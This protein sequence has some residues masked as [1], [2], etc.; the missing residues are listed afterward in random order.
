MKK[1]KLFTVLLLLSTQ[2]KAQQDTSTFYFEFDKVIFT[3]E[4]EKTFDLFLSKLPK[5]TELSIEVSSDSIG[6]Y[7]Y[8]EVLTNRR[9]SYVLGLLN[10]EIVIKNKKVIPE[11]FRNTE[12]SLNRKVVITHLKKE[13]D[14]KQTF[15]AQFLSRKDEMKNMISSNE[16]FVLNVR[17]IGG[18][19]NFL[20]YESFE[21]VLAF[22]EFLKENPKKKILI[23]GHVCCSDNMP[24]S[25]QRALRVYN[26]L[27][28][29]GIS[30]SRMEYKGYSN[31]MLLISPDNT[32]KANEANRRVDVVFVD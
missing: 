25:N 10:K 12:P 9:L 17:F 8:N 13:L 18:E 16:G 11:N 14:E 27:I 28:Q 7:K 20:D 21:E 3:K 19:A 5:G 26:Q 1:V 30:Q 2:F 29:E 23:R 6:D 15:S 24:L 31:K 22:A 32:D 4:S